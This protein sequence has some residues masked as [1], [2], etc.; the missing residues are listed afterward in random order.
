MFL[1]GNLFTGSLPAYLVEVC[2]AAEF[3]SNRKVGALIV[4]EKRNDLNSI[5]AG[6]MNFDSDIKAEVLSALFEKNS[7]VHDGAVIIRRGRIARLK[8]ILP[9]STNEGIPA[10]LG[11]RHRSAIGVTEKTDAIAL[12]ISE[13]RGEISLAYRGK[14]S[15]PPSQKEL[16]RLLGRALRGKK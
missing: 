13:E 2:R 15:N 9:V 5:L 10:Q 3:L 6:G 11:T 8:A 7:N 16:S 14:L 1:Y 4:I 12:V